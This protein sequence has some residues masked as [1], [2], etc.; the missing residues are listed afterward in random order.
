MESLTA[1]NENPRAGRQPK[2][3]AILTTRSAC[4]RQPEEKA[5]MI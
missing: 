2:R 4:Q 1:K 3:G 5:Q